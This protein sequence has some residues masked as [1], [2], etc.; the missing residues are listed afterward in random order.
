[1]IT[2]G[3]RISELFFSFKI[4]VK[5]SGFDVALL[6]DPPGLDLSAEGPSF[7]RFASGSKSTEL[8]LLLV[9]SLLLPPPSAPGESIRCSAVGGLP[10]P[11]L[12]P[13]RLNDE[14]VVAV[15]AVSAAGECFVFCFLVFGPEDGP[16]TGG[17]A[18]ADVDG[19]AEEGGGGGVRGSAFVEVLAVSWMRFFTWRFNFS[20]ILLSPRGIER[21]S[22]CIVMDLHDSFPRFSITFCSRRRRNDNTHFSR[23]RSQQNDDKRRVVPNDFENTAPTDNVRKAERLTAAVR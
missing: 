6:P 8:K 17:G 4:I 7:D 11:E 16:G 5:I 3:S 10:L 1:M 19:P 22:G 23:L 21:S 12:P 20:L 2:S 14:L 18:A 15:L 13:A 9:V